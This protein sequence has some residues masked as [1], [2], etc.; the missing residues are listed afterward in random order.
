MSDTA[1]PI[2]PDDIIEPNGDQLAAAL[3][4][5]PALLNAAAGMFGLDADA[6]ATAFGGDD[7]DA[8]TLLDIAVR[9]DDIDDKLGR[10]IAALDAAAPKL[11]RLGVPWQT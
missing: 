4:I 5:P 11:R 1:S 9:L 7:P 10:I 2:V 8:P 3:G 6:L